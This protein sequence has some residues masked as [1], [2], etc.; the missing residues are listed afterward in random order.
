MLAFVLFPLS[1]DLPHGAVTAIIIIA[2]PGFLSINKKLS[3]E[4]IIS[5]IIFISRINMIPHA[6]TSCV[7]I[8]LSSNARA[9]EYSVAVDCLSAIHL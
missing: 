8:P 3:R 2:M 7:Q 1:P 9:E 4:M 5:L 6:D